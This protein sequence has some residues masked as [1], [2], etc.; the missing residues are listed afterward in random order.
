MW[1]L[2]TNQRPV[3]SKEAG[4]RSDLAQPSLVSAYLCTLEIDDCSLS[5]DPESVTRHCVPAHYS[6]QE[7]RSWCGF[8]FVL[9]QLTQSFLPLHS[10]R[11]RTTGSGDLIPDSGWWCQ[12]CQDL[13]VCT[14]TWAALVQF[15]FQ[16]QSSWRVLNNTV[17]TLV[18]A[19]C[20]E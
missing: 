16:E 15:I 7:I 1:S 4:T 19:V 3:P 9:T 11:P 13:R 18:P 20:S 14:P 2:W 6:D 5:L 17:S 12:D 10:G 8:C